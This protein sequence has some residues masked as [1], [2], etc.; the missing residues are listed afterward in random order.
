[1]AIGN[2]L[3]NAV[4]YSPGRQVRI[5]AEVPS[6]GHDVLIRIRDEGVGVPPADLKQ[7]LQSFLPH[8]QGSRTKVKGT[9]LGLFIVRNILR[10]HRG[11]VIAES[12]GEGK[13]ATVTLRLPRLKAHA[14]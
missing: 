14:R 2:V 10:K 7:H 12:E 13:G 11:G 4:K 9:G 6:R 1:M 5:H 8:G 3:D